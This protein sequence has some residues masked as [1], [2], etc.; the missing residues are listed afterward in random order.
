MWA[1]ELI[2]QTHRPVR[3]HPKTPPKSA[4]PREKHC[5][6]AGRRGHPRKGRREQRTY[7]HREALDRDIT[8]A[9]NKINPCFVARSVRSNSSSPRERELSITADR[10]RPQKVFA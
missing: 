2:T 1:S 3:T 8:G 5:E 4:G 9:A 7:T 10:C 6:L